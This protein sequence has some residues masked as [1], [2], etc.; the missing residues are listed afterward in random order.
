M[1]ERYAHINVNIKLSSSCL[2]MFADEPGM[3]L[4]FDSLIRLNLFPIPQKQPT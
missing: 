3:F 2:C 4:E 1:E